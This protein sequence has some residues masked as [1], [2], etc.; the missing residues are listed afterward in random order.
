MIHLVFQGQVEY[1]VKWRGWSKLHNTWEPE[2]QRLID[3]FYRQ[4]NVEMAAQQNVENEQIT[5]DLERLHL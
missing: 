2:D 3:M 4:Q 1:M 5:R